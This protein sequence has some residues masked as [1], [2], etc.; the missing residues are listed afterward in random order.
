MPDEYFM[1]YLNN[2]DYIQKH[3]FPWAELLSVGHISKEVHKTWSLHIDDI[4]YFGQSYATTLRL[5]L[6]KFRDVTWELRALW[7]DEMF[8]RKREYYLIYCMVWFTTEYIN[9]AQIKIHKK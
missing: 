4:E 1:T 8:M 7:F 2:Q 3:I 5:W 6:E 9:V